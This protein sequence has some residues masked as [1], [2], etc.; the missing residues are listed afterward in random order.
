MNWR[1][2][3]QHWTA[4]TDAIVTRWPGLDRAEVLAVDGDR[5]GLNVLLG[6]ALKLTPRE[7]EEE[8]DAFL[9][10]P[11]PMDAIMDAR[12]DNT[13]ISASVAYIPR[14]EDVYS[15]EADFGDD[16]LQERPMG[17]VANG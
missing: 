2:A 7:A 4:L 14:G 6:R 12:R 16:R 11:L 3:A 17:R 13:R 1:T 8:I 9:A 10:G 15:Q 5:A